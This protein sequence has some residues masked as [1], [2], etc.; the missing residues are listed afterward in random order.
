MSLLPATGAGTATILATST[1]RAKWLLGNGLGSFAAPTSTALGYGYHT[2]ADVADFNADGRDDFAAVNYEY[3]T[4]GVSLAAADGSLQ[5]ST[6]FSTGY[7][8]VSVT[9]GD[10]NGD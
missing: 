10:V 4:V 3:W 1:A 2:G 6:D 5:A 9:A 8:P 7:Y